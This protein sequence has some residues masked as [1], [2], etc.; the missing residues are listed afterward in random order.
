MKYS[1][2]FIFIF[3]LP[4]LGD[5]RFMQHLIDPWYVTEDIE[6]KRDIGNEIIRLMHENDYGKIA[7]DGIR[8]GD[9]GWSRSITLN[10]KQLSNIGK[11]FS[12]KVP[13][14]DGKTFDTRDHL[15]KVVLIDFFA[16]FCSPCNRV[17]K[18]ITEV[19]DM[20]TDKI[21]VLII[22][23]DRDLEKLKKYQ[24]NLK[25]KFPTHFDP[26]GRNNKYKK[27]WGA[28]LGHVYIVDQD[29]L[30]SDIHGQ[31]NLA[32]KVERLLRAG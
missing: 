31:K 12:L 23:P 10:I 26:N 30:L 14:L 20:Y 8:D 9:G 13:T 24:S 28:S 25:Y 7:P 22:A 19:K 18:T 17:T 29:G 6:K 3:N 21:S 2:L 32:Q 5:N 1:V 15:G 4:L 16:T 11:P 27:E